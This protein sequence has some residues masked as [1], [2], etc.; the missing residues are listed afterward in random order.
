MTF[1]Y[2]LLMTLVTLYGG[3]LNALNRFARGGG[4][5][6]PAQRGDDRGAGAGGVLSDRRPCGGLGRAGRRMSRAAA[7]RRRRDTRTAFCRSCAGRA[8]TTDVKRFFAALGPAVVGSAGLQLALFADTIIASFLP[9]GRAV[10][11]VL[12]RPPQ[13]A[14][15]RRDRH[16]GRH[17]AAAG[18]DA[19]HRRPA[20]RP[21]RAMRR[22]ARSSSR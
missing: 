11:A 12:R 2:L 19:A 9:A 17:R 1:P 5:A 7:G 21:A 4:G 22:I 3:I 6:D 20:T 13:S 18:D 8:G 15:D 14:A 10:G 16:R